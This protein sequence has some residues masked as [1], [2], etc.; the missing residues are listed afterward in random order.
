MT[1]A[2]IHPAQLI[3]VVL[4]EPAGALNVGSVARVLK[5]MGLKQ[6]VLV[7][8]QCDPLS[9]EARQMAVHAGDL[10]EA[11]QLVQSLPEALAGCQIAVATTGLDHTALEVKLE[12]P[13]TVLPWLVK[14]QIQSQI[15]AAL[16]FGREDRGLTKHE[17]SYAQ[18]WIRIP[19]SP[20]Y[21][22]LNLAQAVAIC[23]YELSQIWLQAEQ[24]DLE[25]D[26]LPNPRADLASLEG[27]Y[28]Q[29]E[30]LLLKIGYL[31]P[32]TAASRMEKFRLLLGRAQ[33][34]E[35]EVALCRGILR[36]TNW[37]LQQASRSEQA[38]DAVDLD[39]GL[40]TG[41]DTGAVDPEA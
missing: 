7:N 40:D 30:H 2:I 39:I 36:Q 41:L 4:V 26:P 23:C 32:H 9:A 14:S 35:A 17:L 12:S 27:Y 33:P 25:P 15:Q 29:L 20:D 24:A 3:R 13:R 16:I 19:T 31:Y 5:N 21:G 11:A 1:E 22:S 38:V 37:A 6:L 28:Q 10:L 8:P 18:R 34:S